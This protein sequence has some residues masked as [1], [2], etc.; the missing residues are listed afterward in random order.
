MV[1]FSFTL[2]SFVFPLEHTDYLHEA[3]LRENNM[4]RKKKHFCLQIEGRHL[5]CII[6]EVVKIL[7]L[8]NKREKS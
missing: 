8:V 4:K 1:A 5:A 3:S 7:K 2:P 6:L